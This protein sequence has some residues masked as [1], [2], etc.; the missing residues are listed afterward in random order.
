MIVGGFATM[1]WEIGLDRPLGW[2]SV[3]FALPLSV[4]TLIIVSLLTK[5][6]NASA[7]HNQTGQYNL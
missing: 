3:L 1:L 5:N 6:K 4:L 2:N 7:H